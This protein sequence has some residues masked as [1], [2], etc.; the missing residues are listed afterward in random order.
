MRTRTSNGRNQ[1]SAFRDF[2]I[3]GTYAPDM[4]Y[5]Q[6]QVDAEIGHPDHSAKIPGMVRYGTGSTGNADR[7]AGTDRGGSAGNGERIGCSTYV[8]RQTR[9]GRVRTGR[10]SF[11]FEFEPTQDLLD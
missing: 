1:A 7:G 3:Y 10:G 5:R 11:S 4:R 8:V 6:E 9:K 2:G